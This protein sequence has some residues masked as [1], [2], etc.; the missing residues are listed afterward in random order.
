MYNST[1]HFNLSDFRHPVFVW[2]LFIVLLWS[3]MPSVIIAQQPTATISALRGTVLVNGLEKG[4][5]T[6]LSMGDVIETQ[7]GASVV[8]TLSDESLLELG[9]N[10]RLD[11]AELSQSAS[12][13]RVSRV[14]MMWGWVRAKLSPGHQTQGSAFNIETP[15]ALVGVKFSQPDVE[16]SY[17]PATQETVA[18]ALTVALAVK[19]LLTGE[20]MIVPVGSTAIIIGLSIKILSGAV[21][22]GMIGAGTTGTAGG[23]STGKIV[24]IGAGALA[25]GGIAAIVASF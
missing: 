15:N 18:L 10:T 11:I 22:S 1:F 9:E 7:A 5:G 3:C 2:L 19:N 20:E 13:A 21:A 6:V 14:K 4:K 23:M 25:A 24:A 16:V 8:L 17:N 12:G